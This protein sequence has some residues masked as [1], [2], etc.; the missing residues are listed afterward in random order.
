MYI[1]KF[2]NPAAWQ[3]VPWDC[4]ALDPTASSHHSQRKAPC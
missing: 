3:G 4:R 1:S 2:N